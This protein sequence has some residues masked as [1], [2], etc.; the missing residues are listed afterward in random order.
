MVDWHSRRQRIGNINH[1]ES[2]LLRRDIGVVSR[3][4]DSLR[5]GFGIAGD[6][7]AGVQGV[8]NIDDRQTTG[9][10]C[11]ICVISPYRDFAGVFRACAVDRGARIRRAGDIDD[12]H[13]QIVGSYIR[14]VGDDLQ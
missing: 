11:D 2:C 7:L 9:I 8:G 12:C 10:V 13:A 14:E 4:C 3:Y 6:K 1:G 5:V